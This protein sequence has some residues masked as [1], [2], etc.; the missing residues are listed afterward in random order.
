MKTTVSKE[1][2][3]ASLANA[4]RFSTGIRTQNE[5]LGAFLMFDEKKIVV[6]GIQENRFFQEDIACD[7][8]TKET[9]IIT[10]DNKKLT[11]FLQNIPATD[12]QLSLE[13][14]GLRVFAGK[15]RALFPIAVR[16]EVPTIPQNIVNVLVI[17]PK[18]ILSVL[19]QLLFC[20]AADSA[21]PTLAS[22]KCIPLEDNKTL[23][24]TTDGF[25][26]SIVQTSLPSPI[27]KS[28]QIP[29]TF[30]RDVFT[31]VIEETNKAELV[32]YEDGRIGIRQSNLLVGS[33]LVSG[34][35]PPYERVIVRN[36]QYNIVVS[37]KE[38]IQS[39]K[40]IAIFTR[41]FSNIIVCEFK[42]DVLKI[43]PKKEAGGENNTELSIEM[44]GK[45]IEDLVVAFNYRYLLDYL[46]SVEDDF[47][48]IRINRVDSPILFLPGRIDSSDSHEGS[49]YQHI[50]MPVRIQE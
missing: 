16:T 13:D 22:I 48:T 32:F 9:K 15:S 14:N 26:L 7:L 10:T 17:D 37:R 36:Y 34:D 11:E 5:V 8:S 42:G 28:I 30:F 43:R 27:E 4:A 18:I 35:F 25:R 50:I 23:F 33:Q 20:V 24:I 3:H 44:Q 12:I 21:R 38:L 49:A 41:E 46:S 47:V 29:A 31:L 1:K 2:L 45:D 40:T 39:I 19:P 6:L